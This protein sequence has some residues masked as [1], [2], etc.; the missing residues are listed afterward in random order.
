MAVV[1]P[2]G[3]LNNPNLQK[4]REYF[5]GRAKIILITSIPSDVFIASGATVKPSL[6]FLQKFTEAEEIE[7]LRITNNEIKRLRAELGLNALEER[8]KLITQKKYESSEDDKDQ[9]ISDKVELGILK[10]QLKELTIKFDT[11]LKQAI[12]DKFNYQIPIVEVEKAGITTTG[13]PC[14]NELLEVVKEWREYNTK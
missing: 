6:V 11:Q 2:E 7:Y 14:E 13:Q 10:I 9:K 1:L 5:E 3:F 12:K 4:V 8:I